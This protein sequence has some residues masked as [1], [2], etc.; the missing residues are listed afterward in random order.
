MKA[1]EADALYVAMKPMFKPGRGVQGNLR[2]YVGGEQVANAHIPILYGPE[3][4]P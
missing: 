4:L 1:A 2:I 3:P